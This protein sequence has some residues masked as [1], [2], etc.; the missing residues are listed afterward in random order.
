[1]KVIASRERLAQGLQTVARAVSTRTTLPILN[2]V[3]VEAGDQGL[4]LT[5]TNL[6]I[7]I[8]VE[9]E[10]RCEEAGR[11]TVPARLLTDLVVQLPNEDVTLV[12]DTKTSTLNVRCTQHNHNI[13]GID[14]A[15]FPPLPQTGEGSTFEITR[16]QMVQAIE[17][18]VPAASQDEARPVLMGVLTQLEDGRITFAATDGHRLA[19]KKLSAAG[20]NGHAE[21]LIVPRRALEELGRVLKGDGDAV[22]VTVSGQRNQ[23]SFRSGRVELS[24]RLI[25]GT[26]PNYAQ[27]IPNGGLTTVHVDRE[28][29]LHKARAVGLMARDSANVLKLKT[30]E[31]VLVLTAHTNEV[32]DSQVEVPAEIEGADL[33]IAF[34]ARYLIEVLEVLGS[35]Q[36]ALKF[37]GPLSPGLITANGDDDYLHVIMPVRAP[38]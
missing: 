8:R 29:L 16:E 14:A 20:A 7:G 24:S 38:I 2:N 31:G 13:K 19:V 12:L 26:Y 28:D 30:G 3:L 18:T 33:G 35:Q 5:A 25:E 17:Q 1:M 9:L 10:A 37:N 11:I 32:G 23:I 21:S 36:A 22:Q 15:E 4:V 27:V 6:E 34:N